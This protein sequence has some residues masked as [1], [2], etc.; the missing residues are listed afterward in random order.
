MIVRS[1]GCESFYPTQMF[2]YFLR[3]AVTLYIFPEVTPL[4][5]HLLKHPGIAGRTVLGYPQS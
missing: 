1:G 4:L 2:R 5:S 3:L